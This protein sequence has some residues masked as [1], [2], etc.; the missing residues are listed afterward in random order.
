MLDVTYGGAFLAGLISFVSPCVLPI[1]PPYMA[2]LAG[3]TFD[4]L[5]DDNRS[6]AS[7]RQLILSSIAFVLG[8]TTVFVALGT[9]ASVIGQ[10]IA[11]YFDALSV[12][13]G[14]IIIVMGLHF[15]GVFRIGLFYREAR[16]QID[17]RPAG[18]LGAYVLGLAFAFGWTPCVGPVLAAI[19]FV[20]GA[21]ATAARGGLLLGIYSLGIGLPFLL[22]AVFASR[23]LGWAS[24][25]KR[26]MHKIEIAMGAIL[27]V[28]GILFM[29]GQM[30]E[31]AYWL[32]ETFPAFQEFG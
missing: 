2:Y 9:T 15:I 20:A 19:L 16:F 8:F 21:E 28:T 23:F 13:A 1:V 17:R 25:F 14:V 29:T 6:A 27:V 31:I 7:T 12:I 3:L 24:R 18:V 30:S 5:Q 10:S 11:R 22:A 26:H 32:L 4:E